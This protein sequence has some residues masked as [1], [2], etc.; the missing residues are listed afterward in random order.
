MGQWRGKGYGSFNAQ[1]AAGKLAKKVFVCSN[2][3]CEVQ[4]VGEKRADNK[5]HNPVSQCRDCSGIEFFVIDSKTEAAR[6]AQLRMLE[7]RG[8]IVDLKRQVWF[9]LFA[10]GPSGERIN[11]GAYVADATYFDVDAQEFIIEDT[12]P[13]VG[14]DKLA[15]LKFKIMAA[16]GRPVTVHSA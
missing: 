8:K 4:Y 6:Y 10:A 9:D 11:V 1:H 5:W 2:P 3:S 7:K 16:N 12:K 13:M 15:D 14:V